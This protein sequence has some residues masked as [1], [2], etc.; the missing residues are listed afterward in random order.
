MF[1]KI[2]T[3]LTGRRGGGD[4]MS[5]IALATDSFESVS[6]FYQDDLRFPVV[7]QWD[8]TNGRGRRFD[9]NGLRLE[10]LDNAREPRPADLTAPG[11]RVH[12]VIEVDD[13]QA[14]RSQLR[15]P[16]PSP[17]VVSWGAT[18]FQ[19]RDPDGVPITFL[20]WNKRKDNA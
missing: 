11:D 18:L 15:I 5:Y 4:H 17:Q 20:Q 14:A 3:Y 7:A 8:R 12:V 13:I 6:R 16:V 10:I 9:L 19:I 2:G 1:D